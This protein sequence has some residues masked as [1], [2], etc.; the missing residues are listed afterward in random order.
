MARARQR[1]QAAFANQLPIELLFSESDFI[2]ALERSAGDPLEN[3][4]VDAQ[5]EGFEEL[6]VGELDAS[7]AM[8]GR[9]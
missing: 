2:D 5:T 7:T 1:F 9:T 8:R 6:L 4:G 3:D